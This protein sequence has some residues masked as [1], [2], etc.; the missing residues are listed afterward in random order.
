ME[1]SSALILSLEGLQEYPPVIEDC[2]RTAW[3]DAYGQEPG[4]RGK[5]ALTTWMSEGRRTAFVMSG[6]EYVS[7]EN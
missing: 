2:A 5:G 7:E 6:N 1:R 4:P 3:E